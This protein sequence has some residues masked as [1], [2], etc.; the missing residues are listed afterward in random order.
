MFV[1]VSI[2]LFYILTM[3]LVLKLNGDEYVE[4]AKDY[5]T[6][7]SGQF[8]NGIL[9]PIINYLKSEGKLLK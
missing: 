1:I 8:I 4:I 5:S 6:S 3:H 7:K 9:I 2:S